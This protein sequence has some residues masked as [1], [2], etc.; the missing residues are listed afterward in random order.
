MPCS[1]RSRPT[2]NTWRPNHNFILGALLAIHLAWDADPTGTGY[3]V[4][5]SPDL[6]QWQLLATT[7]N[8]VATVNVDGQMWF[9]CVTSTNQAGVES[10]GPVR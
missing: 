10:D 5:G 3:K 1:P 4:Y 9:F 8:T 7:S 2:T 6:I